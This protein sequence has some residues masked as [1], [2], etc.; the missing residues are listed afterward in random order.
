[1]KIYNSNI[2]KA[3]N[4]YKKQQVR[5]T[6]KVSSRISR[7]DEFNISDKAKEYQIAMNALKKVPDI[8]HEKVDEIRQQIKSG[9]YDIDSGKI[10]EKI[11]ESINIDKKI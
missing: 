7:K 5:E 3:F 11:Y 1:M 10:A 2:E 4:V 8:R 6:T 9:T